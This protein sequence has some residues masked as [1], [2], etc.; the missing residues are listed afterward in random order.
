MNE[1][2]WTAIGPEDYAEPTCVLCGEHYGEAPKVKSVPQQRIMQKLDEYWGARDYAGAERH[3]LY[4]LEE[5]RLGCDERGELMLRN[6]LMGHYRKLGKENEAIAQAEAALKLLERFD[7]DSLTAATSYVNVAT[8]Y[9]A[10]S[11]AA[12]AIPYFEM[13]KRIY[14]AKLPAGDSRLGG[15]YNNM[16]LAL[17]ALRRFGESFESWQKALAAMREVEHGEMEQA[18]THLNIA[19][20]VEAEHGL[21]RGAEKIEQC[22]SLAQELLDTPTLPRSGY[23]AFVCEKCA[24]TFDYYGWF[25]YANE[26]K[27]RAEEIYERA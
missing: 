1:N 10:F 2:K 3:L 4:W 11:R 8:V 16:G 13:A 26:L 25:F 21:E 22:L 23:Y 24:P 20:A 18:I 19:N 14:E 15:L 7:G 6:E 5:A 12:A 9:H 17:A 27:N